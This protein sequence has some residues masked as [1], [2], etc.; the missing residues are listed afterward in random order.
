MRVKPANPHLTIKVVYGQTSLILRGAPCPEM[1][2]KKS[3]SQLITFTLT[4]LK[5]L[6]VFYKADVTL[7]RWP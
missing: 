1:G 6:H 2:L 5:I 4:N 7:N 3:L